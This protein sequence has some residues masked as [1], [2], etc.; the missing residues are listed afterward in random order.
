[1]GLKGNRQ[2][3]SG[4][5][6]VTDLESLHLFRWRHINWIGLGVGFNVL[7]VLNSISWPRPHAHASSC[8]LLGAFR[9]TRVNMYRRFSWIRVP[10]D[11]MLFPSRPTQ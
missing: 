5:L 3:R 10:D 7:N 8:P 2:I 1:M 9:V 4:L 6:M 11:C